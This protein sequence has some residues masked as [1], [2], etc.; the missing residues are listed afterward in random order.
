[1]HPGDR[2]SLCRWGGPDLLDRVRV[3]EPA[4]GPDAACRRPRAGDGQ[5]P[6]RG[7]R[8]ARPV[9][10]AST[11]KGRYGV[12]DLCQPLPADKH[13]SQEYLDRPRPL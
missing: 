6:D 11:D 2:I 9:A 3:L 4:T 13:Q 5:P 7:P 8:R 12:F 1:M 10:P